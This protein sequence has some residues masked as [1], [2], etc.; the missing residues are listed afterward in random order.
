MPTNVKIFVDQFL[1]N[2]LHDDHISEDDEFRLPVL[3]LLKTLRLVTLDVR[4]HPHQTGLL[5][6]HYTPTNQ[7]GNQWVGDDD[8]DDDNDNDAHQMGVK[9]N[10]AQDSQKPNQADDDK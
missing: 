9:M 1:A 10:S 4:S 7:L 2:I 6:F 8:D 3:Q 5:D